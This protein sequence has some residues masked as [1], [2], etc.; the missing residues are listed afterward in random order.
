[1][2]VIKRLL[3]HLCKFLKKPNHLRCKQQVLLH[4]YICIRDNLVPTYL[5][6]GGRFDPEGLCPLQA[7]VW[8][9]PKYT[10]RKI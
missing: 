10:T 4:N 5:N 6:V 9:I 1:M 7:G 8:G 2:M 3:L